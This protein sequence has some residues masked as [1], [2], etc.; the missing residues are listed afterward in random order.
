MSVP[1]QRLDA[2]EC[3]IKLTKSQR[4]V[5]HHILAIAA[6]QPQLFGASDLQEGYAARF[7]AG[8]V[9]QIQRKLP[10]RGSGTY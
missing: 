3:L 8:T 1:T 2:G 4:E 7:F 5:L 10:R 6:E 9:S